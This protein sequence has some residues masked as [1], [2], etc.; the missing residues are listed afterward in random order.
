[1]AHVQH[2]CLDKMWVGMVWKP[3]SIEIKFRTQT[4]PTCRSRNVH[5]LGARQIYQVELPDLDTE[6]HFLPD[7]A[8]GATRQPGAQVVGS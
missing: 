5:A 6:P 4:P 3:I 8:L 1:M 7:A 2:R